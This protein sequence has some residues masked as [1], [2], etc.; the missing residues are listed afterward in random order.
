MATSTGRESE[1][2]VI[3]LPDG[4]RDRIKASAD[5]NNR[6]MNAEIVSRLEDSLDEKQTAAS[7]SINID[8]ADL[9]KPDIQEKLQMISDHL[10]AVKAAGATVS[11][12]K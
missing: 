12:K 6:S 8:L 7:L 1:K 2:F 11:P 5:A 4:M 9:G 3:R 10:D